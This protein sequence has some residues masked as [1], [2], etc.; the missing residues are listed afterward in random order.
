MSHGPDN[1]ARSPQTLHTV[2]LRNSFPSGLLFQQTPAV[3][4]R[5]LLNPEHQLNLTQLPFV[6]LSRA[7]SSHNTVFCCNTQRAESGLMGCKFYLIHQTKPS[8]SLRFHCYH[9]EWKLQIKFWSVSALTVLGGNC[10]HGCDNTNG[11]C[12]FL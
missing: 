9:I 10:I 6:F 11:R 12:A 3:I 1:R 5:E 7:A 2:F 8:I 4:P